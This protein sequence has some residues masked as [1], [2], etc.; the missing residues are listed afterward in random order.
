MN[1]RKMHEHNDGSMLEFHGQKEN[2]PA[3][4]PNETMA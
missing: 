1:E 2:I 3:A 4:K